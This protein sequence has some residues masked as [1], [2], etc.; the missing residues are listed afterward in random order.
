[1]GKPTGRRPQRRVK[2]AIIGFLIVLL[3]SLF[4]EVAT[5]AGWLSVLELIYYD[6]WHL[7][8]GPR[9]EPRH[10]VIVSVDTQAFLDHRDEPLV[11]WG[12]YFAQAIEKARRAEARII[13]L[14]YL[15]SV[16][17][18]SWLSKIA[19][20]RGDQGRTHDIPL[21][22]QLASGRVVLIG[23]VATDDQ[24]NVHLVLPIEDYL[25]ALP[26]GLA[27]VGLGNFLTD[28]DGAVRR[29]AP[30]LFEDGRLPSLTFATLLAVRGTGISP[31]SASWSLA[32]REVANGALPQAIGFVG[33]PGAVPRLPF[34]R[35][36]SSPSNESS[37]IKR[38]KDKVVIIAAEH[39]GN[40][41]IHLTPYARGFMAF[42]GRMMSGAEVHAN[43]VETLLTG[44]FP[45]PLPP[46]VR[47]L[48]FAVLLT[49]ATALFLNVSP[50]HGL[51]AGVILSLASTLLGFLLFL[52]NWVLPVAGMQ[53]GVAVSYMITLGIRLTG[54]ERERVLLREMFGKYVSDEVVEKL[55]ALVE[56][57]GTVDKFIGDAVMA[58]F[59]APAPYEDHAARA[60]RA[61][62]AVAEMAREFRAWVKERFA[63][64]DLPEFRI[65]IGLHTGEVVVGSIGSPKR[66]HFTAIGDT[67][68][69]ASRL[70]GLT[71]DLGWTIVASAEVIKAADGVALT[72]GH[73]TATVKGREAEIEVFEVTGLKT[74]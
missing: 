25:F 42:E 70:E 71:K 24:G 7:L 63:S 38:L 18:E 28:A 11:F 30:A 12:P 72:G 2:Q 16:S 22:A 55:L 19:L 34:S 69:A 57:G 59:G 62:V 15:F 67:V 64:M 13:G 44:R 58:F 40:Q 73:K 5:R 6:L 31:A 49:A 51:G 35:L 1:M 61:A 56:Q 33:P 68:N 21:R 48:S 52:G 17:A 4:T 23:D 45:R 29:F 14:D 27:D 43:I 41:D 26:G 9:D 60:L 53:A 10:V 50:W 47:L 54:E 37:D 8:A 74:E 46:S 32:G 66:L 36:I 65:G 3:A 20:V 39:M